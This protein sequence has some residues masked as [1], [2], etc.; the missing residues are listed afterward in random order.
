MQT[1][2]KALQKAPSSTANAQS[3]KLLGHISSPKRK[4]S[5]VFAVIFVY[6]ERNATFAWFTK[7]LL[8]G[9]QRYLYHEVICYLYVVNL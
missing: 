3:V 8:C 9:Y 4:R 6:Y 2:F 1:P 7:V 5:N